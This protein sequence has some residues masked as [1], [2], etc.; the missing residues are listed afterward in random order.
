MNRKRYN[1][2]MKKAEYIKQLK[3]LIKK[4]HPDLC[5]DEKLEAMY[6]KITKKLTEILNCIKINDVQNNLGIK[7]SINKD[8]SIKTNEQDY[9]YYKLGVKY[10]RN[11]HPDKLYKRNIDM[12]FE[13]KICDELVSALNN[14]YLSFNLSEYYFR[15][16]VEE[17]KDSP[18]INDAN[19]K[20]HL[21]KKLYRSYENIVSEE[22]KIVNCK[23][24]MN[25]MGL[26]IM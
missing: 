10:Y 23:D 26:R 12:T 14:I 2:N 6:N 7:N 21:L 17:Y 25:E 22:R 8:E 5:S 3:Q 24:F 18:W 15:K 11:I 1:K 19:E 4:Y 13:T 16:V 20:I 9:V